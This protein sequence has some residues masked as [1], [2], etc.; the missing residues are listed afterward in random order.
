MMRGKDVQDINELKRE[1]LSIHA[2]SELTGLDRKTI[3]KYLL[4]PAGRP[5]YGPRTA[6][7]TSKL[8]TFKPYLEDRLKAGVWNAR[9]LLREL[10]QRNYSG[11]Y[12][13]L[14]DWLRPQR[15]SARVVAVRR[16]E[17]APGK[18]A[19][20]DWGHLGSLTERGKCYP[21]WGF[22][23]A[24]GYSRRMMAGAA[25]D[26]KL[27]TLPRMHE[28]AFE[29]WEGVP[30]ELLYDRMR[31]IWT[32]TDERGEI[33]WNSTFLDFA[34]Y[35]GFTPRLCRPYRAQ[36]KGKV[37]SG[38][39][40]VRRNFLCGLQ[41]R[42]PSSLAELNSELRRWVSEV[43]HQRIH[44]TTHEQVL[45]RWDGDQFGMQPCQG[46]APYPF[47]EDESR[48]VARD[49]YVS[50]QASRYSVPWIYAGKEV[51]VREQSD[52][53]EVRSGGQRIALH[54]RAATQHQVITLR[55]HHQG[56]PLSNNPHSGKTLVHIQ[57]G[58]P[59]VENRPL[60]AYEAVAMRGVR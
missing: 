5:V 40:Y 26:T 29:Q 36:T 59:V 57:H 49:A 6:S 19:Q 25:T 56:I 60:A 11:G 16:F 58:A 27:G 44:G 14:T 37:E 42:E 24:L 17:T 9:V 2:I 30:E 12:T 46:R 38:V 47:A 32:G 15:G 23:M 22:T 35:W 31:T 21:L 7:S 41:G 43:A 33:I 20:V 52:Q 55:E 1:G 18:Q 51:S 34:R 54:A 39:K 48:K 10:R 28:L 8:E 53:V 45:L 4:E 3:R 13:I 50:W